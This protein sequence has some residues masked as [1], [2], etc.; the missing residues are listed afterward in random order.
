MTYSPLTYCLYCIFVIKL[1]YV[2]DMN[3]YSLYL[4]YAYFSTLLNRYQHFEP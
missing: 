2:V 4:Y 1:G 3:L